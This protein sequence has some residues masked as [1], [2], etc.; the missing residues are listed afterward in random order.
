MWTKL[1]FIPFFPMRETKTK[2][3]AV[4]FIP[5]IF[6]PHAI[7]ND[8][9]KDCLMST[10]GFSFLIHHFRTRLTA[11]YYRMC[12][13]CVSCQT[14]SRAKERNCLGYFVLGCVYGIIKRKERIKFFFFR[15]INNIVNNGK[16]EQLG[17]NTTR[18]IRIHYWI[19]LGAADEKKNY[20]RTKT[21][22]NHIL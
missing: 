12:F 11:W 1:H 6:V 18:E 8:R 21:E 16:T 7:W 19:R 14:P 22:V 9:E 5:S 15:N 13:K 2:S 17:G 10:I 20:M 3:C 4:S